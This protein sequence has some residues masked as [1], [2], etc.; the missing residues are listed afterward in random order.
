M[1]H[2]ET[3][4]STCKPDRFSILLQLSAT[5]GYVM[6]QFD[7]KVGLLHSPIKKKEEEQS[8]EFAKQRSNE[9]K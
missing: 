4:A 8:K 5:L 2:F 7:V 6:Q 9:K 3:F 1:D